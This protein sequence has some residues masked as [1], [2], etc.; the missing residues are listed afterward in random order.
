MRQRNSQSEK[1]AL[2]LDKI[3]FIKEINKIKLN[4]I[5]ILDNNEKAALYNIE[6]L[7]LQQIFQNQEIETY[8]SNVLSSWIAQQSSKNRQ[9]QKNISD[10]R[11]QLLEIQ[12]MIIHLRK[13]MDDNQRKIT[14]T[15]RREQL[16]KLR[17]AMT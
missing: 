12:I 1:L 11:N 4:K 13:Q 5:G 16:R 7:L 2:R 6:K 15:Q 9:I 14:E 10:S 8:E 17:I 3:N